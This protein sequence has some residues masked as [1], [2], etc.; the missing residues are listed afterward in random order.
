MRILILTLTLVRLTFT[1]L[2]AAGP[3]D[4]DPFRWPFAS[5]SIWNT[6]IG[7]GA[8]YVAA[9]LHPTSSAWVDGDHEEHV[10]LF[11]FGVI[12]PRAAPPTPAKARPTTSG[13]V[14]GVPL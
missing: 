4:R 5:T 6:P 2:C 12:S 10:L 11:L 7:S 9:G 3:I 1:G 8:V 14:A 13:V